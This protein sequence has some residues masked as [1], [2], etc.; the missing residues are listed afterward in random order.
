MAVIQGTAEFQLNCSTTSKAQRLKVLI[1]EDEDVTRFL[2]EASLTN[3]GHDTLLARDGEQAKAILQCGGINICIL[4]WDMPRIDGVVLCQ[5]IR[6]MPLMPKPHVIMLTS[7]K[8]PAHI[9]LA[10]QAGANEYLVKP[11]KGPELRKLLSAISA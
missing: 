3:W 8:E 7:R 10:L 4:D 9:Q 11:F 6:T 2:L 1:A 5:W